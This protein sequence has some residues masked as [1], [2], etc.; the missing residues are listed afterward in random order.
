MYFVNCPSCGYS[1]VSD[2]SRA[3]QQVGCPKCGVALTLPGAT[4]PPAPPPSSFGP[5]QTPSQYGA[6]GPYSPP[7]SYSG[8]SYRSNRQSVRISHRRSAGECAL[9]GGAIG[10]VIG[11]ML[12]VLLSSGMASE[13]VAG[14]NVSS[15]PGETV[16]YS[17]MAGMACFG[18]FVCGA[19][20]VVGVIA[21]IIYSVT[22]D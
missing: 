11:I 8:G 16:A 5:P 17:M 3:G 10:F 18:P 22:L 1:V 15:D 9:V 4:P 19:T 20:T 12:V 7:Q 21:G 14:G 6:A 13:N 2:P